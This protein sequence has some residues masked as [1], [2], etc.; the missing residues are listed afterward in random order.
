MLRVMAN[1][2]R[3]NRWPE[4]AGGEG[5]LTGDRPLRTVGSYWPYVSTLFDF[6]RHAM[7]FGNAQSLAADEIYAVTAYILGLNDVLKDE[8]YELNERTLATIRLPNEGGF[9]DDDREV[10]EAAFWNRPV[11]MVACR[12]EVRITG[13]AA[14]LD[15][16]P[17][18][19][20]VPRIE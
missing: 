13:R 19:K 3:V 4:L 2:A 8:D 10:A 5:S 11:C 20:A 18:A 17:D 1:S 7:P 15:V 14:V 16:T 12:G 9:F 6:V